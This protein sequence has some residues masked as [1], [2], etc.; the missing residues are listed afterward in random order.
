MERSY[1]M[2][3]VLFVI[4][5]VFI[6]TVNWMACDMFLPAQPQIVEYFGTD[7][8]TLNLA[9]SVWFVVSAAS[10]KA[11]E[12]CKCEENCKNFLHGF[13]FFGV[14]PVKFVLVLPLC[15]LL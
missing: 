6:M 11:E 10:C 4:C 3:P 1:K 8:A 14:L 13:S 5:I 12:H 9:L 2:N 7:A 15:F